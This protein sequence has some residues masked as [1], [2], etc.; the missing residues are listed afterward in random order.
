MVELFKTDVSDAAIA[1]KILT[2]LKTTIE[3][4]RI[5]F[6]LDDCD[7]ILRL[8]ADHLPLEEIKSILH[9]LGVNFELL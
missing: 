1:E 3:F 7:K 6:D 4:T 5:N 9:G 2:D 8:E